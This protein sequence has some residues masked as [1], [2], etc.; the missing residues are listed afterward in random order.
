[1][2][3]WRHVCGTLCTL[4][5]PDLIPARRKE[6]KGDKM[7]VS[8]PNKKKKQAVRFFCSS[9]FLWSCCGRQ[10]QAQMRAINSFLF[11]RF[12]SSYSW[13][14][15]KTFAACVHG[16]GTRS[17]NIGRSNSVRE[18][19]LFLLSENYFPFIVSFSPSAACSWKVHFSFFIPS[20]TR[21]KF[22]SWN[23][24][25]LQLLVNLSSRMCKSVINT[26]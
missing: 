1:M 15:S 25:T 23:I 5:I 22:S 12:A 24:F 11:S 10:Q 14:W 3:T 26:E 2:M 20:P 21:Q 8:T 7:S 6:W 4:S 17:S 9:I 16:D 18:K 13:I 19:R